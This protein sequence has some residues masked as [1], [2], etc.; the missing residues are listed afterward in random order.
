MDVSGA[1]FSF[2]LGIWTDFRKLERK[3]KRDRNARRE[4]WQLDR[5]QKGPVI[6]ELDYAYLVRDIFDDLQR[7]TLS[8][9]F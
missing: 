7:I 1:G 6:L 3:K 2:G 9:K 5:N 8:F 4:A